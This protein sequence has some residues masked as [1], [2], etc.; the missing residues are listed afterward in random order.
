MVWARCLS[1]LC[2]KRLYST[3]RCRS[4][5][6]G[7]CSTSRLACGTN[8][9]T[10]N[11]HCRCDWAFFAAARDCDC[12]CHLAKAEW[13]RRARG[14]YEW[15]IHRAGVRGCY[16]VWVTRCLLRDSCDLSIS[17]LRQT[18]CRLAY[19]SH[20]QEPHESSQHCRDI[21]CTDEDFFQDQK[22]LTL[23]CQG[24]PEGPLYTNC[25]V[26]QDI[27]SFRTDRVEH[28]TCTQYFF[29]FWM[30]VSH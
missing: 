27:L 6:Q 2:V 1:F 20:S 29:A 13:A 7:C 14:G 4:D 22:S 28:P 11:G 30:I 10:C 5:G 9:W 8:A 23:K 25:G 17:P 24:R 15:T 21:L 18:K 16:C 19:Q 3:S 26:T 12:L